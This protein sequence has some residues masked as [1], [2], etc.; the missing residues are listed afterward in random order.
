MRRV[1]IPKSDG[2]HRP[3]GVL[4][5]RDRVVQQACQIVIAPCFEANVPDA[6]YGFR[7]KRRAGQA[8]TVVNEA[9][10]SGW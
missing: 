6:S 3:L 1:D 8:G 10:V 7:P 9:M 4:T 5:V 2:R